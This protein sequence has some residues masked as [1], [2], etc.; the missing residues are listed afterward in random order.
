M[1]NVLN[2][3]KHFKK[4]IQ[5]S[6]NNNN[7]IQIKNEE[8]IEDNISYLKIYLCGSDKVID[9][10]LNNVFTYCV[11]DEFSKEKTYLEYKT[12]Q[13]HW[14]LSD[15]H[16]NEKSIDDIYKEII[17]EITLERNSLS[18][19][20]KKITNQQV[21]ICFGDN[22]MQT[23]CKYFK[24]MREP[25]IIAV[26]KSK[27]EINIDKRYVT[28]I[29]TEGMNENEVTSLI[30]SNLWEL[31]CYY[32]GKGN[33]ICKYTPENIFNQ[34]EKD[35]S[36]F[37]L[38]I[39]LLGK[40]RTGKS[41]LINLIAG[42]MIALESDNNTS[43]TKK[44]LEYYIYRND[45]KNGHSA[46]KFI[47]TPGFVPHKNAPEYEQIEDM[48]KSNKNQNN[49]EKKIHFILFLL[50]KD[51]LSIEGVEEFLKLVL[52]ESNCPVFFIINK[53]DND[54]DIEEIK[55]NLNETLGEDLLE[56][57]QF[58]NAN[59]KKGC[60]QNIYGISEIFKKISNYINDKKILDENLKTK[61]DNLLQKFRMVEENCSIISLKEEDKSK[62]THLKEKIQFNQ[63]MKEIKK[64]CNSND[65]FSSI[66]IN[67]IIENGKNNAQNC[68]E[69]IISL[70][71]LQGIFPRISDKYPL[72]SI[73]QGYMVKLIKDGFGLNK[74]S[75]QYGIA[76]LRKELNNIFE[77]LK[78]NKKIDEKQN[79]KKLLDEG[80]LNQLFNEI[81]NKLKDSLYGSNKKL[82]FK[83]AEILNKLGE[84]LKEQQ[85]D[86]NLNFNEQ[87]TD[88]IA[89][90]CEMF[91]EKEII[92]SKGLSFMVNYYEKLK[93][94][95]ED[96]DYYSKKD[97]WGTYEMLIK[98]KNLDSNK[99]N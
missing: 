46:I 14:I 29:I 21:I 83:L 93:L 40:S 96:I 48:I 9:S 57:D 11:K 84:T 92:E 67:S 8:N 53:G 26:T 49:P 73:F 38:N 62:I 39:L 94:L 88:L 81:E 71:N 37:S 55:D 91:F 77:E 3:V 18:N 44:I 85:I 95:L 30:I 35:N 58:I 98:K 56:E 42:K 43:V 59:L 68:K 87:F 4:K 24:E 76:I 34:L 99:F 74:D 32:N 60:I 25:R 79:D 23:L 70:S 41:T 63:K 27:C 31:D 80:D 66:D 20:N 78:D 6:N 72:I 86:M 65:Y 15:Y 22:N 54:D 36:L 13:F 2:L 7:N 19:D 52:K 82:I 1:G 75:L 64:I 51:D 47:D 45:D 17:D 33:Q 50:M 5:N 61:M 10:L 97:D 28:N 89:Y 12:D 69:V 90:F 16:S